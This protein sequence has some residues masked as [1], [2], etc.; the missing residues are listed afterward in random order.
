M[1]IK[2]INID[3]K[4][5]D[6]EQRKYPYCYWP[7]AD[8][9]HEEIKVKLPEGYE[10]VELGQKINFKSSVA[11]YSI[12]YSFSEGI[13]NIKKDLI[14]KKTIVNPDEYVEFKKFYNDF[15]K[16]DT[17]QILLKRII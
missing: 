2:K 8:T 4:L 7:D 5:V 11:D 15:I 6:Y 9:L 12:N 14:N 1:K 17:Q 16:Q 10:P 3:N 13:I